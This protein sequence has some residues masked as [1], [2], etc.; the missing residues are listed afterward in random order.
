MMFLLLVVRV[1]LELSPLSVPP[2]NNDGYADIGLRGGEQAK[3]G[4]GR[5]R[6]RQQ[7]VARQLLDA[8]QLWEFHEQ[9]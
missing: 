9:T 1:F 6:Q 8:D 4:R 5:G 2:G 7:Q 3:R